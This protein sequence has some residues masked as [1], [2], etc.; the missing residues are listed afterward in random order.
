MIS[1]YRHALWYGSALLLW[2]CQF[3][4]DVGRR[5]NLASIGLRRLQ[6]GGLALD[7]ASLEGLV[8]LMSGNG[9]LKSQKCVG[10]A[11][12]SN[13]TRSKVEACVKGRHEGWGKGGGGRQRATSCQSPCLLVSPDLGCMAVGANMGQQHVYQ[14][15][16]QLTETYQVFVNPNAAKAKLAGTYGRT[17]K[18]RSPKLLKRPLRYSSGTSAGWRSTAGL[19]APWLPRWQTENG[20][21]TWNT[22][23]VA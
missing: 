7:F 5:Q 3:S 17:G 9:V 20:S 23:S 13:R 10:P 19:M 2:G 1:A 11:C 15:P 8:V 12:F 4:T 21:H 18:S 16:R 6:W 14:P 22:S